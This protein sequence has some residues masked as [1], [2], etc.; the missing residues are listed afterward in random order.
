MT[1]QPEDHWSELDGRRV[2]YRTV[3]AGANAEGLPP[4]LL[5]HGISCC[6]GTWAPFVREL[7]RRDD[8][9]AVIVPELPAHGKSAH[10]RRILGMTELADWMEWLLRVQGVAVVDVM[11]HSMGC[12]IALA[13]ADQ[14]PACVRKLI[15]LGPTTGG[16]YVSALRTFAGLLADSTREPLSYNLLLTRM[17]W[18]MG[19][20]HYLL[21]ARKMQL[22]DAHRHAA[23]VAAPTLVL[24]G[25]RDAIIPKRAAMELAW[26]LCSSEYD[27]VP[28]AH[29]SQ[30]SHPESTAERVLAFLRKP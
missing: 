15:L 16:R 8:A 25:E 10:P 9:P 27:Q 28:G 1:R 26:A 18:R 29:A 4:L 6:N 3:T 5:I 7:A 12:Q 24:Q 23:R 22:D 20:L 2:F 11:G 13:L 30:Y 14:Y 17:F 21:T 19:P